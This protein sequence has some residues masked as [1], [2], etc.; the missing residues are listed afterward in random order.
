[1]VQSELVLPEVQAYSGGWMATAMSTTFGAGFHAAPGKAVDAVAAVSLAT[2]M[3]KHSRQK[4]P[5]RN[6]KLRLF[7]EKDADNPP[8][9][10]NLQFLPQI[11][12]YLCGILAVLG[13]SLGDDGKL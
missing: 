12:V 6:T 1:M 13:T 9:C 8:G 5:V 7:Y 10:R 3:V 2:V 11:G 4:K